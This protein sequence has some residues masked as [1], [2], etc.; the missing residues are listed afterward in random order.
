MI[1]SPSVSGHAAT[2]APTRSLRTR[3]LAGTAAVVAGTL[4]LVGC[5][6]DPDPVPTTA[7]GG[8]TSSEG[9]AVSADARLI[10]PGKLL[11]CT[12]TAFRP[13]EYPE[14][15]QIVGFDID[16]ANWVAKKV[17]ATVEVVDIPFDQITSGAAFAAKRCD[18]GAAAITMNDKR[19]SVLA[20]SDSYFESTQA[21]LTKEGAG[22]QDLA[23]L[24]GKRLAVQTDTTGQDYAEKNKADNGYTTVVFED[25]TSVANAVLSGAVD[26]G[27]NDNAVMLYFAKNNPTTQVVKEIPTGEQYGL[28]VAKDNPGLLK[29]VNEA[30]RTARSDG[31]YDAAYEKYFG[32]KP[33]AQ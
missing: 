33:Q 9:S 18:L 10:S 26:A 6:K 22:Y 29:V 13:F 25:S 11:T 2:T 8:S 7:A 1:A 3:V 20:F 12:H 21:L 23:S 15:D 14:G 28:A 5:A 31:T 30:L 16:L 27:L 24:K 17:D 4:G 32:T 19:R